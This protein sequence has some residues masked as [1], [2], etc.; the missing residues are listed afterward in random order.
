MGLPEVGRQDFSI[1][2]KM[3]SDFINIASDM[4]LIGSYVYSLNCIYSYSLK[5][6]INKNVVYSDNT[7]YTGSSKDREN[8]EKYSQCE[9]ISSYLLY[10]GIMFNRDSLYKF[11]LI[12]NRLVHEPRFLKDI[13]KETLSTFPNYQE[14]LKLS[15]I[16]Y[17][18]DICGD[19]LKA[20]TQ[21]CIGQDPDGYVKNPDE[22]PDVIN[23]GLDKTNSE[24]GLMEQLMNQNKK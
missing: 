11:I 14:M 5:M 10:K 9:V 13:K 7:V 20:I 24:L 3:M 8:K 23:S 1:S 15:N 21:F 6:L 17:G 12:R 2:A 19:Y 18:S 16:F 22:L 4:N